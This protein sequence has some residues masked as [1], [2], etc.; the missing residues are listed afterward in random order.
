MNVPLSFN[1][2]IISGERT[3]GIDSTS[4]SLD[5]SSIKELV[6]NRLSSRVPEAPV[7]VGLESGLLVA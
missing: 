7:L 2:I 5:T 1:S 4:N 6:V 3:A